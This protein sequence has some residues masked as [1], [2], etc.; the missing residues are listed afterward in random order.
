MIMKSIAELFIILYNYI[1]MFW[2]F[3]FFLIG[4]PKFI[5]AMSNVN[6][7]KY[8]KINKKTHKNT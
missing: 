2:L 7:Y 1:D 5:N 8:L 6:V 3:V 4:L